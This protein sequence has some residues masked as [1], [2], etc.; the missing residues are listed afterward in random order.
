M[1]V[2]V[3]LDLN[4]KSYVVEGQFLMNPLVSIIIPVYNVEPYIEES[5]N[6]ILSQSYDNLEII[7]IDDGSTDRSGSIC[8]SYAENDSRFR[9][10]HQKKAGVSAARNVGLDQMTGSIVAFLDP[11]D[12]YCSEFF[13][14]MLDTMYR[15]HS[16]IVVCNYTIEE[17]GKRTICHDLNHEAFDHIFALRAL[18]DEKYDWSLWNKLYD[19]ALWDGIRFPEGQVFED[20]D[21]FYKVVERCDRLYTLPETLYLKRKRPGSITTTYSKENV[22]DSLTA[23]TH[24]AEFVKKNETTVFTSEQCRRISEKL[25]DFQIFSYLKYYYTFG[26]DDFLIGLRKSICEQDVDDCGF[27]IKAAYWSMKHCPWLLIRVYSVKRKFRRL[28]GRG[29]D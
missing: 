14:S 7:L 8:D 28:V 6:S 9:V 13:E 15:E 5:L 22:R 27:Y 1:L 29:L 25:V 4:N 19:R 21:I 2:Q 17:N 10:I 18:V 12:I 16:K 20:L 26:E 23:Y 3:V 11:D 24:Y